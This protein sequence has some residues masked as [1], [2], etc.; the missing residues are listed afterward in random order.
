MGR[1]S[2]ILDENPI[3]E[4]ELSCITGLLVTMY[5]VEFGEAIKAEC[6]RRDFPSPLF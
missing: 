5:P 4:I 1:Y 3:P 2:D 6:K